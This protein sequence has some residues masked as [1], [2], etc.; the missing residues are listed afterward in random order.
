MAERGSDQPVHV[1]SA[2]SGRLKAVIK[3][4]GDPALV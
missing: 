2:T 4:V 3:R 1:T